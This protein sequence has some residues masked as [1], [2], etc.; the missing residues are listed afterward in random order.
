M[1]DRPAG[2]GSLGVFLSPSRSEIF[3]HGGALMV[4]RD[5]K[6]RLRAFAFRLRQPVRIGRAIG[7]KGS[8]LSSGGTLP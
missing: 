4:S 6:G 7:A 8:S 3:E 2:F 5:K 1:A